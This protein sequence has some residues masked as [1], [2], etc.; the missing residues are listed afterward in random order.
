MNRID[1]TKLGGYPLTQADLDFLQAAYTSA[2]SGIANLF[3]DK[4]IISGMVQTGSNVSAGWISVAGELL[5]FTAGAIGSGGIIIQQ[6]TTPKVFKDGVSKIVRYSRNARFG[7]PGTYNY[8]DF[9]RLDLSYLMPK[10]A[11]IMWGGAIVDIP[12]GWNLCDG[13]G[14]RPNLSSKFIVGYDAADVD[15]NA[16]GKTGGEKKHVLTVTE[17][18]SH[19]HTIHFDEYATGDSA[20]PGYD[21]GPNNYD[22]NVDKST[23]STGGNAAHE[24]RPPY[25]TLAYIIKL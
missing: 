4:V 2:F 22:S 12:G 14:G 21:G 10:G 24:N 20:N 9:K 8:S 5:P 1:F 7:T 19:S 17:M 6:T 11:I 3:G 16:I 18:P 15:Y 23:S 13:A 25:Y